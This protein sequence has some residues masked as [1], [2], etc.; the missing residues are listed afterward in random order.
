MKNQELR[1]FAWFAPLFFFLLLVHPGYVQAADTET[2]NTVLP[3]IKDTVMAYG[4]PTGGTN[5]SITRGIVSRIDFASYRYPVSGLRIQIDAAINPGNSGGPALVGDMMIGLA[6]SSLSN[7]Q[8]I[9]YIIPCEEIEIFLADI[10]DGRYDGK[11]AL[12]DELQT[13]ENPALR[14][15]HIG[16]R[17]DTARPCCKWSS[18]STAWPSRTCATS[19]KSCATP[20]GNSS[21]SNSP[22]GTENH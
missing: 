20:A 14:S 15:F 2:E 9:G 4:Y 12:F 17:E 11:P 16:W 1:S 8:N 10:A 6:F 19:S 22:A 7:T 13:L 21:R 3:K 5:L 18:R